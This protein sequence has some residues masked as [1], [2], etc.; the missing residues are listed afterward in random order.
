[1]I[2]T[3]V[4]TRRRALRGM[5]AGGA[6]TVALPIFDC[7]LNENGTALADSGAPLP[8][9]FASWF[10]GLGIG[11]ND[12]RPKQ[13]GSD[14]ELP[15]ELGALKPFQKKLNLFSGGEVFLDG[16]ANQTHF[17]GVQGFMTGKVTGSGDYFS[18][19]DTIIGDVI[20]G[21]MRFRSIEVACDG[22]PKASWSARASGKQPAEVSPLALYG[23][24]FGPEFTDPNAATFVPDPK[25]MVRRSVLSGIND[26]RSSL[27]KRLG[28]GDRA[29]L[30]YYFTSLRALEQKL[31]VQ[32][33]KPE[34]LPS[35]S[36]PDAPGKDDGKPV[37]LALDAMARH[38]LFCALMTHALACGQTRV[39]NLS[40]TQ[41]M[42]GLRR[43]GDPTNHHTYTHEEPIDSKLGYQV[44][45]AWFQRMY[46]TGLAHFAGMLD[47]VQEG[48]KTLLDRMIL[49]AYTDHGAPRLHSLR[50]YPFVTFGGANGRM[51]T[52]MHIPRP[53]DAATR[54]TLTVQQAMG[55]P[56]SAWGVGS[57]R[58]TSPIS[59]VLI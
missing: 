1:M 21:P 50:N 25:V 26:E 12:W 19:I 35:C 34:P 49:F 2:G 15:V 7:L 51:K 17:T 9:R 24:V 47:A 28:A 27:T 40:I 5:L 55:V 58:V 32:L 33:Q 31:D 6:V 3:K 16:Q 29:K 48:D 20:S 13:A 57:N 42:S 44:K 36:K 18:S 8:T 45:C 39:V 46:M 4:W 37:S 38:D 10:W 54:V 59:E 23:R 53:G 52:G 43:E 41:G 14:Y 30:D 11:E 22:D 56:V